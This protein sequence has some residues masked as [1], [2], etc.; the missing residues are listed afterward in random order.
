MKKVFIVTPSYLIKK[1]SDFTGGI[2]QLSKLNFHV[3]NPDFPKVLPS[4]REKADQLHGAFADPEIDIVLALRGGY[5]AMKSLPYID[6]E[7]IKKH[8]KVLAGFSDLSALLNPIYERTGLVTLHS[9]MVINLG[10]PTPFTLRSF[11]NAVKGYPEKNLLKGAPVK[12]Y[13]PGTATGILKGGNLITLTAL[14]DTDW[15]IDT[16]DSIL[17]LEDVDEK[18]HEVDRYLTQWILAGKFRKVKALVLGDFRG[19]RSRQVYDILASQME[20]NFPVVHCPY[21]GHVKNKI[22]LPVG[23]EVELNTDRKQM[24]ICEMAFPGAGR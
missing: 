13:N 7:L 3:I 14:I 23:A 18:L 11:V 4:P 9:P 2:K 5:S 17:F 16:A 6:F 10:T 15:E 8:R 1:K 20:L 12:V 21:I 19:I 22:T 24:V